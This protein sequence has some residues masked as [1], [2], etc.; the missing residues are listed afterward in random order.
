MKSPLFFQKGCDAIWGAIEAVLE[1][2]GENA[3][4]TP[5]QSFF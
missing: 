1:P 3:T 4:E 2:M 5:T